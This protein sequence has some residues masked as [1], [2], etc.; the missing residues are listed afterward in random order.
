[1][2]PLV[3]AIACFKVAISSIGLG[4]PFAKPTRPPCANFI[5]CCCK[6]SSK[7]PWKPSSTADW[8]CKKDWLGKESIKAPATWSSTSP[9]ILSVGNGVKKLCGGLEIS[10][11]FSNSSIWGFSEASINFLNFSGFTSDILSNSWSDK[12]SISSTIPL[13][14]SNCFILSCRS[15]NGMFSSNLSDNFLP[16]L[17]S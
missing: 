11:S 17:N 7:L 1:M 6:Y 13:G 5:L 10:F 4:D 12:S 9:T 2:P 8:Y 16:N 14:I 3:E 15:S